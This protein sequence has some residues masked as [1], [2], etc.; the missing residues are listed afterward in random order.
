[1]VEA[2]ILGVKKKCIY[3]GTRED[4]FM[5]WWAQHLQLPAKSIQINPRPNLAT[6]YLK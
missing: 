3:L 4:I 6:V 5:S 2:E 1:M